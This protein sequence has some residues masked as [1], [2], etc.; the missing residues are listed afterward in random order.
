[1]MLFLFF[2][3]I[4]NVFYFIL[5]LVNFLVNFISFSTFFILLFI[6]LDVYIVVLFIL[7]L[8][9]LVHQVNLNE[10]NKCSFFKAVLNINKYHLRFF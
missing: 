5:I 2:I 6:I 8:V 3:N 4:L 9:I 7:S 10:N 1:M